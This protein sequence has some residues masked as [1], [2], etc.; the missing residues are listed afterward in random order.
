VT[1]IYLHSR[2]VESVFE[3]LGRKE[4]SITFSVGW[5]LSQSPAFLI[6]LLNHAIPGITPSDLSGI[7]IT[8]QEYGNDGGY[9]DI[10]IQGK[11]FS[12]IVEAKRG[13]TLPHP[14]Q[15]ERYKQRLM[16]LHLARSAF[17]VL[18]ECSERYASAHLPTSMGGIGIHH[19]SWRQVRQLCC[20]PW[21][22]LPER[23]ILKELQSYLGKIVPMQ[24]MESNMVYVVA[25]NHWEWAPGL[26]FIQTVQDR[27]M[28]FHPFAEGK[29]PKE[30]PNYFGFRFDGALQQICHVESSEVIDD[31]STVFPERK[32]PVSKK[33]VLYRLGPA[34]YP[35][36]LV[37]TG[38]V[39]GSG[40]SKAMLDLLLT[41]D[42]VAEA[43]RKT[44]ERLPLS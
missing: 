7:K 14:S 44:K 5:A 15:L 20:G 30:P 41:C 33:H 23:R 34:I 2:P 36:K 10:E 21:K 35:P 26:T 38:G 19:L 29:W 17:V 11:D 39:F 24:N 3:L 37:K 1:E 31:L 43:V 25:L 32:E 27:R 4:N 28:Y 8:L 40:H 18:S 6:R 12:I 9:T 22:S 16:A 42:T 13:W